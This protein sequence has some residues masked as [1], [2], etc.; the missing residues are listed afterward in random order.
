MAFTLTFN[1]ITI[2]ILERE[3]EIATIRTIGTQSWKI[4]AMTTLEN[5]IYGLFAIIPGFILG[6]WVG[7][8]AMGLQQTDYFSISFVVYWS[9]YLLVAIGIIVILLVCQVPSLRYVKKVELAKATKE[10]GG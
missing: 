5:V 7:K 4:S 8:Y 2:N 3:R 1:T 9:S 6:V 10:R